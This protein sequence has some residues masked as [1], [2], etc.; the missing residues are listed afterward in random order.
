MSFFPW[1]K[2]QTDTKELKDKL[3][4]LETWVHHLRK[5]KQEFAELQKAMR[6]IEIQMGKLALPYTN[7]KRQRSPVKLPGG[8]QVSWEL[9]RLAEYEEECKQWIKE[10]ELPRARL[11]ARITQLEKTEETLPG[12]EYTLPGL[13]ADRRQ[14]QVIVSD[15]PW[16]YDFTQTPAARAIENQY[17]TMTMDELKELSIP[18]AEDSVLFLWATA[19]KLPEAIELMGSWGFRYVSN[20]VWYKPQIGMGYYFRSQHEHLLIGIRGN[21]PTP[22]TSARIG[23]VVESPRLAHSVKPPVFMEIIEAMYP[24]LNWLEM[25]ARHDRPGWTS[26]GHG[27]TQDAELLEDL[28]V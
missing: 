14:Y 25:F 15:P 11:L 21:P 17:T 12:Y 26:W 28:S 6:Y 27:I 1:C 24:D 20:A 2:E 8:F 4:T 16:R 10:G 23:S 5:K 22:L 19:P 9:P 18:A 13:E 3:D 7:T